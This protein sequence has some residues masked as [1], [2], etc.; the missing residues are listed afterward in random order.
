MKRLPGALSALLALVVCAAPA[1]ELALRLCAAQ[2]DGNYHAAG[3]DVAKAVDTRFLTVQLIETGGSMDNL[4]RMTRGECDAAI[5]QTDAYR[6]YQERRGGRPVEVMPP[7]YLYPEY[8]HLVCPRDAGVREMEDLLSA[9]PPL[10]VL[11]GP[12]SGGSALTWDSFRLLDRR[13]A[14]VST[15]TMGGPDALGRALDPQ[16]PACLFFV[17]GLRSPAMQEVDEGG[18]SL[19]LA[20]IDDAGF[21]DARFAARPVYEARS[22]PAGT[23]PRLQGTA[24][25]GG[26]PTVTVGATLVVARAWAEAHGDAHLA[27]LRGVERAQ[28]LINQRISGG[29]R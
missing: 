22:I 11:V 19:R 29:E 26:T 14:Q 20:A 6:V 18:A 16:S 10:T 8:A 12:A 4:E 28:P 7:R 21:S 24:S 2:A 13:Y 25:A 15:E 9:R 27:L 5:V 17:S 1:E 23:Y 3:R